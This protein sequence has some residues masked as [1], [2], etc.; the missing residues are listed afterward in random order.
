MRKLEGAYR[1][2]L[3]ATALVCVIVACATPPPSGERRYGEGPSG[4]QGVATPYTLT[5]RDFNDREAVALVQAMARDF[6]GY[7]SHNLI[8]RSGAVRN[9]EYLSTAKMFKLEEWLYSVL[10]DMG[11]D[12]E[13]DVLIQVE[14]T[15][16]TV[17][18]LVSRP[19]R[20]A[21]SQGRRFT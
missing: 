8:A 19:S 10:G 14:G 7:R 12:T 17:D 5:L 4:D 15:Q 9:Y 13:R 11:F 18:K 6:P 16:L 2:L 20:P 21:R 1:N 3:V